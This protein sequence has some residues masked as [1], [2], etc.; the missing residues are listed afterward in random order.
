MSQTIHL[1]LRTCIYLWDL[2]KKENP[3]VTYKRFPVDPRRGIALDSY[4]GLKKEH[5]S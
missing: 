3:S 5:A 4:K 2:K 1:R